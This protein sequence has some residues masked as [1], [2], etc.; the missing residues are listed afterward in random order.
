MLSVIFFFLFAMTLTSAR[1]AEPAFA[2]ALAYD[3][4]IRKEIKKVRG[5]SL[6]P[7]LKPGR[8]IALQEGYYKCHMVQRGDIVAFRY[9]GSDEPVIKVVRGLPGDTF[10]LVRSRRGRRET[11]KI[12][13]NGRVA[14]N[15]RRAP[16][17]LDSRRSRILGLYARASKGVV[18]RGAYIV[19]GEMPRGAL[20]STEFGFLPEGEII[21]RV[22]RP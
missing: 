6:Y 21:G 12:V 3:C 13:I 11:W 14:H 15:S 9:S 8:P 7:L 4:P 5:A 19:L 20:D 10:W 16:F 17:T 2:D 18:P 1:A 22:S